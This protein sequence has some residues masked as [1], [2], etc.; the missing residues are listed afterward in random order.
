MIAFVVVVMILKKKI[1]KIFLVV[2]ILKSRFKNI[3]FIKSIIIL[4]FAY[5]IN[6]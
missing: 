1:K 2:I 6:K 3:Y 4:I 5:K